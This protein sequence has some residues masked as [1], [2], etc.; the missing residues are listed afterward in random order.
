MNAVAIKEYKH[1]VLTLIATDKDTREIDINDP[2]MNTSIYCAASRVTLDIDGE[3]VDYR[4]YRT[5][6]VEPPIW[7]KLRL[8]RKRQKKTAR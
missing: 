4:L 6:L 7:Y 5:L 2:V 8:K 1:D 3:K